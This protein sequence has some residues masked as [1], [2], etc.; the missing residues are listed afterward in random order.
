MT[1]EPFRGYEE[2]NTGGREEEELFILKISFLL[3]DL[4]GTLADLP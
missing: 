1:T 4:M 3:Q 2:A